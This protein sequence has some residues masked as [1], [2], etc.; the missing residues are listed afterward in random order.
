MLTAETEYVYAVGRIRAIEKKLLDKSG[1]ERMLDAK[2]PEEAL[3]VLV[4]AGYG[5]NVGDASNPFHYENLL[6]EEQKK[7]FKLLKEIAP[8][9]EVFDLFLLRNDYHNI[10]TVLKAEFLG[11]DSSDILVD[12]GSIEVNKLKAM[13]RDRNFKEIPEIMKEAIE[14]CMDLFNRT[15]D[16]QVIDVILDKA[17]FRQMKEK[18]EESKY[19]FLINIVENMIDLTNIKIFLRTRNVG[20]SWDAIQ[21]MLLPGGTVENSLFFESMNDSLEDFIKKLKQKPY[22]AIC[23]EGIESFKNT[24]S[25]TG[26]EKLVDNYMISLVKK[27]KYKAFGIE[28]L[29]GYLIAKE[30]EIK[31]ARIVMVGKIN[32]IPNE[33]IK[34]RLR[35]TYV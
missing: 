5:S 26:F 11:Q 2:S 32:N 19:S 23:E 15:G 9:P 28:P 20:K 12:S 16:P 8:E 18:A 21:K 13:I 29:I 33:V 22:G 17:N 10:K 14:E 27:A 24:G 30:N 7:V 6:K 35:E 34:E 4:D 31:N 3:K 25:F 1:I